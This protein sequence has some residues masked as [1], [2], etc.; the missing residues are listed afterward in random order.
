LTTGGS[1]MTRHSSP[2]SS[3]RENHGAVEDIV[4]SIEDAIDRL[5][6]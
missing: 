3:K 1:I 2:W 4:K 6:D 5:E